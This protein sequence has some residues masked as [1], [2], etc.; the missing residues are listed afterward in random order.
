LIKLTLVG[1]ISER[2]LL[3]EKVKVIQCGVGNVGSQIVKILLQRQDVEIVGALELSKSEKL[4]KDLG[5]VVGI[6]RQ[7]GVIVTDNPDTLFSKTAADIVIHTVCGPLKEAYPQIIEPI[8]HGINVISSGG[9]VS[10]PYAINPGLAAKLD[11][12]CKEHGVTVLGHGITPGYLDYLAL[13]MTGACS[14]VRKIKT[15]RQSDITPYRKGSRAWRDFGLG[16]TREE[17]ERGVKEKTIVGHTATTPMSTICE[18]MGWKLT[19]VSHEHGPLFDEQGKVNGDR[20]TSKG[21]KDGE[22]K[23]EMVT[24]AT[25]NVPVETMDTI[26]IEGTPDINMVVKPYFRSLEATSAALVNAI[27]HVIN[28]EPGIMTP[29]T[30]PLIFCLDST[31]MRLFL[32]QA[33]HLS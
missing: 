12:L 8:K 7:V 28:A 18:R 32:K 6:G 1:I 22:V 16:L 33:D 4:G 9:E 13:V 2:S 31:D 17:Y 21:I 23:I 25:I 14:E 30:L 5:E 29:A 20:V 24:E 15:Y 26:T 10:N 19:E 27:P 11:S 3:V